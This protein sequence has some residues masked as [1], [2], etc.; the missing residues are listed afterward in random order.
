MGGKKRNQRQRKVNVPGTSGQPVA[1]TS[2]TSSSLAGP[3][4]GLGQPE[5]LLSKAITVLWML[6]AVGSLCISVVGLPLRYLAVRHWKTPSWE[7]LTGFLLLSGIC[8]GLT[9][10]LLTPVVYRVRPFSP[11]LAITLGNLIA[12]ALPW[13]GLLI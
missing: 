1:S 2:A 10:V 3:A 4:N 8:L 7:L 9:T 5:S 6:T 11:P 12:S 13:L